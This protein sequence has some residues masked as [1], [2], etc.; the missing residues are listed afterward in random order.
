MM[1]QATENKSE[2]MPQETEGPIGIDDIISR[3]EGYVAD[4]KMVTPETLADL[5]GE[6]KDL[7]D[8][9]DGGEAETETPKDAEDTGDHSGKPSLM[10]SIGE[11]M[12][13]RG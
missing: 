10:I 9:L 11:R 5:L 8:Y 12:K 7:K 6:L 4:P 1:E 13:G 3:V 2:E